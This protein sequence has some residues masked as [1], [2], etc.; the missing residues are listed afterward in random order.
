MSWT[1]C[2]RHNVATFDKT[3]TDFVTAAVARDTG[4]IPFG[5]ILLAT[6]GI[7]IVWLIA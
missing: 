1:C 7:V 2:E 3:A 4:A 6:W 5:P